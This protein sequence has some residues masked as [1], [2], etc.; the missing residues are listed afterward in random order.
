MGRGGR[1]G[2]AILYALLS[3]D[4][5]VSEGLPRARTKR[6]ARCESVSLPVREGSPSGTCPRAWGLCSR[7][8]P[9]PSLPAGLDDARCLVPLPEESGRL[10]GPCGC[11]AAARAAGDL[12]AFAT[13]RGTPGDSSPP[14]ISVPLSRASDPSQH[15]R[16][17]RAQ[18]DLHSRDPSQTAATLEAAQSVCPGDPGRAARR[19]RRPAHAQAD[20]NPLHCARRRSQRPSAQAAAH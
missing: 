15:A 3:D 2:G 19:R 18:A 20:T 16:A 7:T 12:R 10:V 14:D 1:F 4:E 17:P 13:R 11:E 9:Q 6:R 8:R 5:W